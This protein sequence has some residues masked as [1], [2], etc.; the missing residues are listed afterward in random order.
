[1]RGGRCFVVMVSTAFIS[2]SPGAIQVCWL[3]HA[4]QDHSV[5]DRR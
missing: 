3:P 4:D 5:G 1:M 2:I